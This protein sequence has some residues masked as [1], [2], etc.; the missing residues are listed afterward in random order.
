SPPRG[1]LSVMPWLHQQSGLPFSQSPLCVQ[2]GCAA[3][4][5]SSLPEGIIPKHA[6]QCSLATHAFLR[7]RTTESSHETQCET[8][9]CGLFALY[10]CGDWL[11][12][13]DIHHTDKFQRNQ[14]S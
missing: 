6:P 11:S 14:R 8:G 3:V 9:L 7:F 1:V 5:T 13:S 10:R 4:L 12:R 2:T